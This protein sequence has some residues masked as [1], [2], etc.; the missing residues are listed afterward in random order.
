LRLR[1]RS[2]LRCRSLSGDPFLFDH[3]DLRRRDLLLTDIDIDGR[4]G[5][6]DLDFRRLRKLRRGRRQFD[7]LARRLG[8]VGG[9]RGLLL[10]RG[11]G[12]F[13]RSGA[14]KL[15]SAA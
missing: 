11:R 3:L 15:V 9:R 1:D 2:G 12:G 5:L 6:C 13:G 7:N 14:Q 4:F 8:S 10:G